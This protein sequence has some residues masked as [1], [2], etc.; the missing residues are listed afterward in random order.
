MLRSP[1]LCEMA[2]NARHAPYPAVHTY[3]IR[4]A[5]TLHFARIF[6]EIFFEV[7]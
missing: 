5:Q 3:I 7:W 1:F 4:Y 2:G 6:G